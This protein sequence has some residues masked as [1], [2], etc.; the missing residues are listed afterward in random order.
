MML[1]SVVADP[2]LSIQSPPPQ[3]SSSSTSQCGAFVSQCYKTCISLSN[4]QGLQSLAVS[5]YCTLQNGVYSVQCVCGQQD[6]TAAVLALVNVPTTIISTVQTTSTA[7]TT[8]TTPTT[9]V[10]TSTDLTTQQTS[11]CSSTTVVNTIVVS[12]T[13]IGQPTIVVTTT[14]STAT[15]T[16]TIVSRVL[17]LTSVLL[18]TTASL[19][20]GPGRRHLCR[21][22]EW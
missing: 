14:T 15:A 3:P 20:I 4:S 22:G 12:T 17:C 18:I 21:S 7:T 16:T 10:T 1:S 19:Y 8:I 6:E 9:I 2:L 11:I 5:H 13:L